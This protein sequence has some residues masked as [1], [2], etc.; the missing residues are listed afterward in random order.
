MLH[1]TRLRQT[2]GQH[3]LIS[4]RQKYHSSLSPSIYIHTL[5]SL[6]LILNILGRG[7]GGYLL[8]S[9]FPYWGRGYL[10]SLLF[11]TGNS[12]SDRP[13]KQFTNCQIKRPFVAAFHHFKTGCRQSTLHRQCAWSTSGPQSSAL[14]TQFSQYLSLRITDTTKAI[15]SNY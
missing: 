12:L 14:Y 7:R 13:L 1:D 6:P 9:F 4:F 8:R 10:L 2:R 3:F 5:L 11:R 15:A